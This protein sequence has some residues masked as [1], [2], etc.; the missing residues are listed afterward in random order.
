MPQPAPTEP[1]LYRV[2]DVLP[3]DIT[4]GTYRRQRVEVGIGYPDGKGGVLLAQS[5]PR[6]SGGTKVVTYKPKSV[7]R[8]SFLSFSN[9]R[10]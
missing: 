7:I 5:L 8:K 9:D 2:D 10:H 4:A 1:Y 6:L 3:Q